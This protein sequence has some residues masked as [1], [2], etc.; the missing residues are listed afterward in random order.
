MYQN[1]VIQF[2]QK[3]LSSQQIHALIGINEDFQKCG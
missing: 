3:E 2:L 1:Q